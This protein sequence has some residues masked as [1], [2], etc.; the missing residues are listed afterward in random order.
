MAD[1]KVC[2]L[3][4][5]PQ[6]RCGQGNIFTPVHRGGVYLS[7]CW[8][9]TPQLGPPRSRFPLGR[10]PLGADTPPGPDP[11]PPGADPPRADPPSPQDQSPPGTRVPPGADTP[12]P[13]TR[14]QHTVYERPVRILLECILVGCEFK[15]T[16][17]ILR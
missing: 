8:D 2:V 10:H 12:P 11:S 1:K 4:Y 16:V 13:G 5:R 6:R 7:A 3:H 9:T 17:N 15:K 14:L